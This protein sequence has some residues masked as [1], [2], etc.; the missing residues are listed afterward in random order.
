MA[1]TSR[2]DMLKEAFPDDIVED[3]GGPQNARVNGRFAYVTDPTKQLCI[4][5]EL[6]SELAATGMKPIN[7]ARIM[8]QSDKPVIRSNHY[9]NLLHDP[10]IRKNVLEKA[11][12][13]L[14]EAKAKLE[15]SVGKA[16]DNI[17]NRVE[18]G[19]IAMSK[20]VLA[21]QGVTDR[22]TANIGPQVNVDFGSW[23]STVGQTKTM[24]DIT[25]DVVSDS[26]ALPAPI[27][28]ELLDQSSED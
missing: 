19:D 16:A 18:A 26:T 28:G 10:R 15:G 4:R 2:I 1:A 20:Y 12:S 21:T 5:H 22:P 13:A 25:T 6:I 9:N 7:I 8:R 3:V 23:L 14:A 27:E 11:T 17:V 24:H